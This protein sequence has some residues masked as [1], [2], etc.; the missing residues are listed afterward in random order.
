[1]QERY[2]SIMCT[3]SEME[4]SVWYLLSVPF[5][6]HLN[7]TLCTLSHETAY[8]TEAVAYLIVTE[9]PGIVSSIH[10]THT[11]LSIFQTATHTHYNIHSMHTYIL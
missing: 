8:Y 1:M 10:Y 2:N 7:N 5:L 11:H 6:I 3:T 9:F 4:W